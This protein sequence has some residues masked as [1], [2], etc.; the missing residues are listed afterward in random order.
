MN[1]VKFVSRVFLLIRGKTYTAFKRFSGFVVRILN[2]AH[3]FLYGLPSNIL[4]EFT[5]K[6]SYLVYI[7][8]TIY[9]V[10]FSYYTILRHYSFQTHAFDLGI[11]M[12]SFWTTMHDK[13]FLYTTLWDGSRFARHF[14]PILFFILPLYA[15]IPQAETLLVLQSFMLAL[16]ALPVYW[17]ARDE[18]GRKAG[19]LYS[20]LY[21]LYPALHGINRFDFHEIALAP[22]FLLFSFHYLRQQKYK[23]VL[24]FSLLALMCK[25][26][27]PLAIIPLGLYGLWKKKTEVWGH[28]RKRDF[29]GFKK[30][31]IFVPT[32]LVLI[33]ISWLFLSYYV[34]FPFFNPQ[35]G[36]RY[37]SL[38]DNWT[39]N[40][41][42]GMDVKFT[43]LLH[44]FGPVGFTSFLNP[45]TLLIAL[46][47]LAQNFLSSRIKQCTIEYHYSA[48]IIPFV[49]ISSIY[50]VKKILKSDSRAKSQAN[51]KHDDSKIN[52]NLKTVE[53]T[54]TKFLVLLLILNVF[55][56]VSISPSPI[57]LDFNM[58]EIT[59]H[60]KVL[61]AVINLIPENASIS[62]QMDIFPHVCHNLH[63]YYGWH[64]GVDYVLI[65]DSTKWSLLSRLDKANLNELSTGYGLVIA[66][67]K[68]YLFEKG[69]E[70]EPLLHQFLPLFE[71]GLKARYYNNENLT[72]KAVFAE[73]VPNVY[74]NWRNDSPF[75][76]VNENHFSAVFDGYLLA[77]ETGNY[78]FRL[79]SDDGSRLYIDYQLVLDGWGLSP[80]DGTTTI[81]LTEGFHE[82]S[83]E[84]VEETGAAAIRL[85]WKTPSSISSEKIP[86]KYF[87]LRLPG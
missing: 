15:I 25:E 4:K 82:I 54:F 87:Y 48:L 78:T 28:L 24:V 33:G 21:L 52:L 59:T 47:E 76:S 67:D 45:S 10:F 74:Y 17:I 50:G 61:E 51:E 75:F 3:S 41:A 2:R 38:Y 11:F 84:Y 26:N 20:V 83:V 43:Y 12:Q 19:V 39:T 23:R 58:P 69:Y 40:L 34:I 35:E 57:A 64:E 32:S 85:Y 46:P 79:K 36:Y 66:I 37:T 30:P 9:T 55:L 18:L 6:P 86:E 44:L 53:G 1:P 16:G 60:H 72:G 7:F 14:S 27:V 68:I 31:S 29:L 65:D 49:F 81:Y 62:T 13:T 56:T 22:V 73:H 80:T 63:A 5:G 8:I 42:T 77:P 70:Q 71:H